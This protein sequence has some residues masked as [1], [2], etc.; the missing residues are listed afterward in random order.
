VIPVEERKGGKVKEILL[1]EI[2]KEVTGRYRYAGRIKLKTEG[3]LWL[4]TL[5]PGKSR[6][7]TRC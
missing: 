4:R 6:E 1:G 3:T 7:N 2:G 5:K